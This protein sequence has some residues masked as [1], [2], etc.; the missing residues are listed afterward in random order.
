MFRKSS[1]RDKL[2]N[3]ALVFSQRQDARS[4]LT[5]LVRGIGFSHIRQAKRYAESKTILE[6]NKFDLIIFDED[7]SIVGERKESAQSII[8][9][10]RRCGFLDIESIVIITTPFATHSHVYNVAESGVDCYLVKPFSLASLSERVSYSFMR[11]T[12][13]AGI[14]SAIR[15]GRLDGALADCLERFSS[16]S[17]FWIYC[18][19][20]AAEIHL[21]RGEAHEAQKLYEEIIRHDALPWA[22]M[23][24][25]RALIDQGRANDALPILQDIANSGDDKNSD[26]YDIMG[27]IFIE[28]G[29]LNSALSTYKLAIDATPSSVSRLQRF[30]FAAIYAGGEYKEQGVAALE[31]SISIGYSSRSL[32]LQVFFTL[33]M[34]YLDD[35]DD[36]G[37]K[38]LSKRLSE[39]SVLEKHPQAAISHAI[40]EVDAIH[41]ILVGRYDTAIHVAQKISQDSTSPAFEYWQA[42][43]LVSLLTILSKHI[44]LSEE[45]IDAI[46]YIGI[47]FSHSEFSEQWIASFADDNSVYQSIIKGCY[48][49]VF[50]HT[51]DLLKLCIHGNHSESASALVD[52]A[53]HTRNARAI[54]VA[55]RVLQKYAEKIDD[56][57][58]LQ[59]RMT[60]IKKHSDPVILKRNPANSQLRHPGGLSI[61]NSVESLKV[62]S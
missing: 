17:S 8:D 7:P 35:N 60:E 53:S 21:R 10:L 33:A 48:R 57:E 34:V 42:C 28:K 2:A 40:L 4:I 29:D 19:R 14:Y 61:F 1:E 56:V 54:E 52:Y 25:C 5:H 31:K 59:R 46:R 58:D 37:I 50:S 51:S 13:L 23:G 38:N 62:Q 12:E 11:R 47:R 22:R 20:I 3:S 26:A 9:D 43:N 32:D 15:E 27:R 39:I 45:Y 41:A 55:D 30:G 44:N 24:F 16:K 49:S 36:A 6:S 18:A